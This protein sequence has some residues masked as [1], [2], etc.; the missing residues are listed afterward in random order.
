MARPTR[1]L[2]R[3]LDS[4]V[5]T[6]K[7]ESP[8]ATDP[9]PATAEPT[10]RKAN[11]AA[12]TL[13]A[14]AE[15]PVNLLRPNPFQ[16]RTAIQDDQLEALAESI[17]RDGIIQPVLV[18]KAGENYEI[19]AGE[20]RWRASKTCDNDTIPVIVREADD[21]KMLELALVENIHRLDLNPIERAAAYRQL[22]VKFGLTPEE[23][24]RRTGQDRTTVTNYLRLLDLPGPIQESVGRGRLSMGHARCLLGVTS[25][26]RRLEL[27]ESAT[28]SEISVRALEEMVR[29]ERRREVDET[30][31]KPQSLHPR[32]PHVQDLERRF[33]EAVRCKVTIKEGRRKGAGRVVIEYHSLDDFDRIASLLGVAVE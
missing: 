16:P 24:G 9:S 28:Q 18:R 17:R 23:V 26:S 5:S 33:E 6:L 20:R 19:I 14:I 11:D 22:A 32:S 1:R 27:A 30:A 21:E 15:V 7:H 8:L 2:G 3:G 4:L 13:T 12:P 10:Q 31:G 29:Q 25:D